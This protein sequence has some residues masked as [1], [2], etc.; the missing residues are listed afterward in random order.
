MDDADAFYASIV[1]EVKGDLRNP[2]AVLG[3]LSAAA[4]E[5]Q[6][7][8]MRALGVPMLLGTETGL[9]AVRHVLDYCA[10]Q[11]GQGG[12]PIASPLEVPVTA[13]A[14]AIRARVEAARTPLDEHASKR[15]LEAYGLTT[16]PEVQVDTLERALL[17]AEA[18]GYPVALK[19]C[20]DAHKTEHGGVFLGLASDEA[21]ADAY[22]DLE[23]RLGPQALVQQMIGPGTEL[24]LGVVRDPQFG[25]MLSLGMGGIFVEI[26]KDVHM[27]LLPTTEKAVRVALGR[28]RGR[29]LLAGARGRP[30]VDLDAVVHAALRLAQLAQD[31]GG[32]FAE[33]DINPLMAL[34]TGAV[35]VDALIVP[36][37]A[38]ATLTRAPA[39]SG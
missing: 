10:H 6:T 36:A 18:I 34:P 13:D 38:A 15:I 17:A 16:T 29:A 4:S 2:I 28:L 24:I 31:L 9:R 32:A 3:H 22:A 30:P 26:L 12:E 37:G 5:V 8:G 1:E 21:L 11:R 27:L 35:V 23:A 7:S 19:T 33:I 25:P 39:A 20:G 14:T